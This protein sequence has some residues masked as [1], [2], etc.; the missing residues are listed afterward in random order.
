MYDFVMFEGE[1]VQA[2]VGW[3]LSVPRRQ[4]KRVDGSLMVSVDRYK[5][6]VDFG[7]RILGQR[8]VVRY[9][10]SKRIPW[11]QAV[12]IVIRQT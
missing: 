5:L 9:V 6:L 2:R 8:V 1:G 12:K 10:S 7:R 3:V 4:R 11:E